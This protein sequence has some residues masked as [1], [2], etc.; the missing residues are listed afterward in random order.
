MTVTVDLGGLGFDQ[1][2]HLLL[3]RALAEAGAARVVG[4]HPDLQWQ[5]VAWGRVRGHDVA[6]DVV[7]KR[8]GAARTGSWQTPPGSR[9]PTCSG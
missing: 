7:T 6:G 8:R 1:G 9:A 3:D 4:T 5:L 2:A